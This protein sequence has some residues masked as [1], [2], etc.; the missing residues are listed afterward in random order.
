MQRALVLLAAVLATFATLNGAEG[1]G[2]RVRRMAPMPA[3]GTMVR[4]MQKESMGMPDPK[5]GEYLDERCG[6]VKALV[7]ASI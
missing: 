2:R 6:I 3:Y 1:R 5:V 4:K 7:L